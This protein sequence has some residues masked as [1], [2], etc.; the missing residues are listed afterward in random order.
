MNFDVFDNIESLRKDALLGSAKAAERNI[1]LS[2]YNAMINARTA[3][4]ALCISLIKENGLEV[5]RNDSGIV[6][7]A[8]QIETCLINKV[9][10]N[11]EAA[12]NVRLN[13]NKVHDKEAYKLHLVRKENVD[14]AIQ[15]VK[16]L[17]DIMAEVYFKGEEII[18]DE[19]KIPFG[20]YEVVRAVPKSGNEVIY[21]DYNYFV[22]DP[23]KNCFYFQV[24]S[25]KDDDE[26]GNLLGERGV[27]AG[28]RIKQDKGRHNYLLDVHY[29]SNLLQDS[30]RDYI[31]YSVYEDS[32]LLSEMTD[33]S[34][35]DREIVIIALDIVNALIELSNI[36]GG[37]ALRN[38]QPGNVII[39]PNVDGYMASIVNMETAK[40]QNYEQTVYAN[41]NNIL[42]GNPYIHR[43][44]RKGIGDDFDWH[45]VDIY[46]VAMLMMYCKNPSMVKLEPD[47]DDI[48]DEFPD[49]LADLLIDITESSVDAIVDLG[50]FKEMLEDVLEEL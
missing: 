48:Y 40:I 41:M 22:K 42:E 3:I 27:L 5:L 36:G 16:G 23:Y 14:Q 24:L 37:I 29:P 4:E 1:Y 46:A 33:V 25:R 35:A 17:F 6:N 45:K 12:D 31:A 30:D 9:F 38:I 49:S 2:P 26:N 7:L 34:F 32:K 28:R 20:F 10:L 11:K 39:T 13:G 21:G 19:N 44:V 18:F 50:T 47:E 8:T 43:D 15:S